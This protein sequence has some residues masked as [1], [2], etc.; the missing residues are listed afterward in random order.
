MQEAI[1]HAR[2]ADLAIVGQLDPDNEAPGSPLSPADV[3][4]DSGRPALVVPYV[5][6]FADVG[7][8]VLIGWNA[9]R[10]AARAVNDALPLLARAAQV[11][12]LAVNPRVG[13]MHHGATPGADIAAHLARHGITVT[14]EIA[15][16]TELDASDTLLNRAADLGADLIVTGAYGRSRMRELVLGGVTRD[17]LRRMTVPVFMSH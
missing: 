15:H 17:L 14:V 10:E 6:R 3:L 13:T 16:V 1:V 4:L 8:R 9:S 12:V 5:G 2:Y 11:T 7:Q